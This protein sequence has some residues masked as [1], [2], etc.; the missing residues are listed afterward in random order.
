[1]S[2]EEVENLLQSEQS[3]HLKASHDVDIRRMSRRVI[4][5]LGKV[6]ERRDDPHFYTL[7][8]FQDV[9]LEQ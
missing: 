4:E 8:L 7:S 1:M 3:T 2:S 6:E 5:L 9:D